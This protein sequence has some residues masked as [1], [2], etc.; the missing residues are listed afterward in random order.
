MMSG[1]S[2]IMVGWLELNALWHKAYPAGTEDEGS[3][4]AQ[5]KIVAAI[6]SSTPAG[7]RIRRDTQFKFIGHLFPD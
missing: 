1:A 2:V 5:Q 4:S 3:S 7:E 6:P